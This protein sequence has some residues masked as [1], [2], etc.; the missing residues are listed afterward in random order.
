MGRI[1]LAGSIVLGVAAALVAQQPADPYSTGITL[2]SGKGCPVFIDGVS[3]GS[4]AERAGIH[5]GDLLVAVGGVH[6]SEP[7]GAARRLR[8]SAPTPVALTLSRG[9]K[10]FEVVSA[11]EKESSILAKSGMKALSGAIVP[12]DTTQAE[13][14]RMLAFDGQ[15][16]LARVFPTHYPA[17]PE[18][19]YAGFEIFVLRDPPQV[20]VGGIEDG[21][22]S[23]AGLHWGDVL[24]S[25]NDTP[26][27]GKTPAELEQL[28]SAT[29]PA[30]VR[31]QIDRLGSS[32]TFEIH[33][34]KA[35][36]VARRNGKR[37]VDDQI[38][39]IWATDTD[40]PCLR[41]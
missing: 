9:G 27:A 8:S 2:L 30:T 29:Q 33:L 35:G 28:F 36:D 32:R 11:F 10:A 25:V 13:V 14:D 15:R 20:T 39:P 1:L 23:R 4:P 34:E 24:V 12:L 40:L 17:K 37:F 38:V 3:S 21:P 18:L 7:G 22:A 41:D 19:F 5:P 31:L 26:V 6:V 16:C